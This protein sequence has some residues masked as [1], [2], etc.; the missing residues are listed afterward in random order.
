MRRGG[1]I[2]SVC[3]HRDRMDAIY[4]ETE[5]TLLRTEASLRFVV[6]NLRAIADG[7][8]ESLNEEC[9]HSARETLNRREYAIRLLQETVRNRAMHGSRTSETLAALCASALGIAR[10]K[11][12][13]KADSIFR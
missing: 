7:P 8:E 5:L 4:L 1:Q 11:Q 6:I 10:L 2:Q 9:L 13:L 12:D 3:E